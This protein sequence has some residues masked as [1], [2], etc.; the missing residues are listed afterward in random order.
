MFCPLLAISGSPAHCLEEKC[1]WWDNGNKGCA[2]VSLVV[3]L[4]KTQEAIY[5]CALPSPTQINVREK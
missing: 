3:E 4:I 1:S 2:V 5:S